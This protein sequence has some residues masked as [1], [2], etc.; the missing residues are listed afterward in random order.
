MPERR[1]WGAMDKVALRE[2]FIKNESK[3]ADPLMAGLFE[4]QAEALD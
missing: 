3:E 4:G 2:L 1:S